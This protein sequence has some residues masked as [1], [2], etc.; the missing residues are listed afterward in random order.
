MK[1]LLLLAVLTGFHLPF[2]LN[3]Q[4]VLRD[5]WPHDFGESDLA[6]I[7]MI[8]P[9]AVQILEDGSYLIATA[10][11]H[12][13]RLFDRDGTLLA[14]WPV[15]GTLA[16]PLSADT[17]SAGPNIGDVDGDGDPEIVVG[18][19]D[20]GSRVRGIGVYDLDGTIDPVLTQS[21]SMSATNFS[22]VVLEN[23]DDDPALEIVFTAGYSIHALDQDGSEVEG[24][25][26]STSASPSQAWTGLAVVPASLTGSS[27][28]LVWM[29]ENYYMHA[30]ALGEETELTGWPNQFESPGGINRAGPVIIPHAEGWYASIV[31]PWYAHLWDQDGESPVGFPRPLP[32]GSG[33]ISWM[34]VADVDGDNSPELLFRCWNNANLHAINLRSEYVP[35]YPLATAAEG[36]GN[37]QT[38]AMKTSFSTQAKLFLA[39]KGEELS[40]VRFMGY[41]AGQSLFGFPVDLTITEWQP[42]PRVALFPPDENGLMSMVLHTT[43]GYTS[44]YDLEVELDS[45][46]T[47]EWAMPAGQPTGNPVY[48]PTV[49]GIGE[50]PYFRFSTDSLQFGDVL[51]YDEADVSFVIENLGGQAGVVTSLTV[52]AGDHT[53]DF[54]VEPAGPFTIEPGASETVSITWSPDEPYTLEG[55]LVLEHDPAPYASVTEIALQGETGHP[56]VLIIPTNLDF[57][58]LSE[59]IPMGYLTPGFENDGSGV[60]RI[61]TIIVAPDVA[62]V[63]TVQAEYPIIIEPSGTVGVVLIWEPTEEGAL[64]T[65][66]E[67]RHNDPFLDYSS[68]IYVDGVWILGTEESEHPVSYSL[69]Q[70]H[71]NPFNPETLI[72]YSLAKPGDVRLTVYSIEGREV[73]TLVEGYRDTGFHE[74]RFNG[75]SLASGVYLYRLE[76]PHFRALRK[77]IL[78]R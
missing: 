55:S 72:R 63:L 52:E 45:T 35:L 30:R 9:L 53:V 40:D 44:V 51:V 62:D 32:T 17:I 48:R 12:D 70:N 57:G 65:E 31:D 42:R 2:L 7:T 29:T 58:L 36:T 68:T 13:I 50:A 69:E 24:F 3:A 39:A 38:V 66:L 37:A 54:T 14:E 56:P 19:R 71:P 25:P 8:N 11:P 10:T 18:L 16:D 1:R 22:N 4:P 6:G 74:V 28:V 41:Q 5:G 49:L 64:M 47:L 73:Q 67:V 46:A 23:L 61:D 26:W 34:S 59:P 15:A 78:I 43:F 76:T 27:P 77:M 20:F 75:H 60:G 21:F 33:P